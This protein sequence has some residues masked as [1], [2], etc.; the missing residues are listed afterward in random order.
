VKSG[1]RIFDTHT[2]I[3]V[4]RHSGRRYSADDLLRDMDLF[5]IERSLLIP[6]PV[7]DD[8]RGAHDLIGAAVRAHADR[9]CGAAIYH[10]AA[11]AIEFREEIQRCREQYDFRAI[12]L[13]PQYHGLNPFSP[14]SDFFFEA[15]FDQGMAAVCH[16]GSGLPFSSPALLMMPA[17]RFPELPIVAA[18]SGG[19]IFVHEAIV[20]AV[21]CPNVYLELSSLMPHHITDILANV[22][23]GRLMIGSDLPVSVETE[24]GKILSL[25]ISQDEKREI[26]SGTAECLFLGGGTK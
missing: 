10:P 22:P 4:A 14:R 9:L 1:Y 24:I 6:F 19:G 2:H 23:A 25:G 13:Q 17:R 20:A 7:I 16:T 8:W 26:L 21:F 18:H 11:D 3:G 12:K 15:A 5:G